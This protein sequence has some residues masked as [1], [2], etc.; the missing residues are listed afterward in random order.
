MCC[1]GLAVVFLD[2]RVGRHV[3]FWNGVSAETLWEA[4]QAS[5]SIGGPGGGREGV[6]RFHNTEGHFEEC[7]LN[8][9][10]SHFHANR[11]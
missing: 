9:S 6:L 10:Q 3:P 5:C 4:W 7:A 8:H 1:S 2:F 11:R